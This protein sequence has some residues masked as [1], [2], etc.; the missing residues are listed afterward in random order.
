MRICAMVRLMPASSTCLADLR[1]C[2]SPPL[3]KALGD[4]TRLG[5]LLALAARPGERSVS[6]LGLCCPVDLSVVS[7]HLRTLR[8]AGVVEARR[9]GKEVRYRVRFGAL[10]GE[11]RRLADAL[12]ACCPPE[13]RR[14]EA[15]RAA[16]RRART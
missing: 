14:T 8:E 11:L 5:I 10:A 1:C 3:F 16:G 12:D 2:L 4:P 13:G 7:R 9:D 15:A 6:E